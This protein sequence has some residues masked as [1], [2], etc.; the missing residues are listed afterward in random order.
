MAGSA[1]TS[2]GFRGADVAGLDRTAVCCR[3]AATSARRAA[4]DL[5]RLVRQPWAAGPFHQRFTGYLTA[6][7]IPALEQVSQS[8][9]GFG[10]ALHAN[11]DA[12]RATSQSRPVDP[13]AT[14]RHDPP[15]AAI[16][17]ATPAAVPTAAPA[18]TARPDPQVRHAAN[19]ALVR[20]ELRTTQDELAVARHELARTERDHRE[21]NWLRRPWLRSEPR[22]AQERVER[23]ERREATYEQLLREDVTI[24]EFDP[25]A[26]GGDGHA[27]AQVGAVSAQTRNVGIL[28]PGMGTD[29]DNFGDYV[30]HAR[31][32][33]DQDLSMVVWMG[34]DL[35]DTGQGTV[36]GTPATPASPHQ[37]W[38]TSRPSSSSGWRGSPRATSRTCGRR[39]SRR[40]G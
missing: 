12:Q 31:T 1:T 11:A 33:V 24:L 23:L 7:L 14:P 13:A 8:L 35:P 39:V 30:R 38:S 28:V 6:T 9:T 10:R 3:E 36:R 19:A 29:L 25:D 15:R 16:A 17:D 5:R 20:E 32:F 4:D 27:V 34:G 21:A 37:T 40:R 18:D 22:D 26:Y 2:A